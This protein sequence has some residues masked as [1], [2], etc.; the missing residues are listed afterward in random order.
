MLLCSSKAHL[1][2]PSCFSTSLKRKL[3]FPLC[4]YKQ[5]LWLCD[6]YRPVWND[7]F[8]CF[9]SCWMWEP[10][11]GRAHALFFFFAPLPHSDVLRYKGS[12]ALHRFRVSNLMIWL[13]CIMRRLPHAFSYHP[14]IVSYKY[15]IKEK[16]KEKVSLWWELLGST[17][18]KFFPCI[19][20]RC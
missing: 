12:I 6:I 18:L 16:R 9:L 5:F 10:S 14:L 20:W 2:N 1:R 13:T 17:L 7:L 15:Q 4:L 8:A 11:E 3:I 19:T